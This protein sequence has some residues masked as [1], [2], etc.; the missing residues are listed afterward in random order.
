MAETPLLPTKRRKTLRS[1]SPSQHPSPPRP[2]PPIDTVIRRSSE[3][4]VRRDEMLMEA[5]ELEQRAKRLREEADQLPWLCPAKE[6]RQLVAT[7][8]SIK[9]RLLDEADV[10]LGWAVRVWQQMLPFTQ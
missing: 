6:S 9:Q 4:G 2:P 1:I 3:S 5:K 7:A 10:E 8:H